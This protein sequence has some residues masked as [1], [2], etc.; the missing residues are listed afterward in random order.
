MLSCRN[1]TA[2]TNSLMR[3]GYLPTWIASGLPNNCLR[4]PSA[5]ERKSLPNKAAARV[6]QS[7]AARGIDLPL[8]NVGGGPPA[9]YPTPIPALATY[10]DVIETSVRTHLQEARPEIIIEPGRY[11]GRYGPLALRGLAACKKIAA[12]R[13]TLGLL[14]TGRYIADCA[15]AATRLSLFDT[16]CLTATS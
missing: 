1:S 10:A 12:R 14:D 9:Q 13:R 4:L 2:S 3:P 5:R 6:L 15:S 8:L 16:R 7:C 11:R